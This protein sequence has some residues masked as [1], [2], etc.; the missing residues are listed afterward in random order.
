MCDDLKEW[1]ARQEN[2]RSRFISAFTSDASTKENH[3]SDIC[4]HDEV[5]FHLAQRFASSKDDIEKFLEAGWEIARRK[6]AFR[7]NILPQSEEQIEN[8]AFELWDHLNLYHHIIV[9][10]ILEWTEKCRQLWRDQPCE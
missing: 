5:V 7:T 10:D 8:W 3:R 9:E 6:I 4:K 1:Q 2:W